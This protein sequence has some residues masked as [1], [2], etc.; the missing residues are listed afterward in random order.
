MM[1]KCEVQV[2]NIRLGVKGVLI[3]IHLLEK[4]LKDFKK[5]F[6][7]V[8]GCTCSRGWPKLRIGKIF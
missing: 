7:Y 5:D 2:V 4:K 3:M 8:R 6:L 1:G